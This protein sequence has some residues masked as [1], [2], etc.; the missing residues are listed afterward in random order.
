MLP[1]IRSITAKTLQS[2]LVRIGSI[3]S[4]TKDVLYTRFNRDLWRPRLFDLR[5]DWKARQEKEWGRKLRIVSIDMGIKNLAYCDVEVDYPASAVNLNATLD[6]IRW[7]K[8]DLVSTTRSYRSHLADPQLIKEGSAEADEDADPYSVDVMSRT[9]YWVV[10]QV[11]LS[12]RPDI[13]LIERQRWRSA[14]SAAIQQWTVRVNTL[15]AMIWSILD[16]LKAERLIVKKR[17]QEVDDKREYEV[18]GVDPKRVGQFWLGQ[19][20]RALGKKQNGEVEVNVVQRPVQEE[21]GKKPAK[22]GKRKA[23]KNAKIAI[24]RSWLTSDTL[25][26]APSATLADPVITFN[27]QGL[28][29][30]AMEALSLPKLRTKRT[31]KKNRAATETAETVSKIAKSGS[32]INKLDD[33]TDCFLQ[34]AAWI[35]WESNRK[36][37]VKVWEENRIAHAENLELDDRMLKTMDDRVNGG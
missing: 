29:T 11:I 17:L 18:Y 5:P 19:H 13:I 24:L 28:A 2:L 31:T 27:I 10:K 22:V 30:K 1:K 36:Q 21:E 9:A 20:A 15:E 37:L 35:T 23:E 14:S 26:T 6:V 3:S 32:E 16:T 33:I 12:A 7:D 34:A 25:S 8:I 4:G